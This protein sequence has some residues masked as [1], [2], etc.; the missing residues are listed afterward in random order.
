M[1]IKARRRELDIRTVMS[2]NVGRSTWSCRDGWSSCIRL[3][4][5]MVLVCEI[6][7]RGCVSVGVEDEL[8]R[9]DEPAGSRILR[10]SV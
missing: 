1:A 4:M 3:L 5:G 8:S 10:D 2:L 9:D 7:C 6:G